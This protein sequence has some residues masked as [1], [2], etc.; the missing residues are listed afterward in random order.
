MIWFNYKN[1]PDVTENCYDKLRQSRLA[2]TS[3]WPYII[4]TSNYLNL[5][6]TTTKKKVRILSDSIF[7]D[8]SILLTKMT[9]LYYYN[10]TSLATNCDSMD[11]FHKHEESSTSKTSIYLFVFDY[12]TFD[13]YDAYHAIS[14]II[15][16]LHC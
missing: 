12:C 9:I 11:D 15:N 3:V 14:N 2:F 4:C 1:A 16:I 8:V 10:H 5:Y 7:G 6:D 13:L